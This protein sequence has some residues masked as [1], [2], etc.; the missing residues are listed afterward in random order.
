MYF[1]DLWIL[2]LYALRVES[3][4]YHAKCMRFGTNPVYIKHHYWLYT[5]DQQAAAGLYAAQ[6]LLWAD[7]TINIEIH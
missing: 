1:P 2:H 6:R 4:N 3:A 5:L 7:S